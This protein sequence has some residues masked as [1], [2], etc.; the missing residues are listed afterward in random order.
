MQGSSRAASVR[1]ACRL[2]LQQRA[3]L[4]MRGSGRS[5]RAAA[6][7]AL[8]VLQAAGAS[9]ASRGWQVGL[10]VDGARWVLCGTAGCLGSQ[11]WSGSTRVMLARKPVHETCTCSACNVCDACEQ[12][13]CRLCC[14]RPTCITICL[15]Q[16]CAGWLNLS[17]SLLCCLFHMPGHAFAVM[18]SIVPVIECA[19]GD[20]ARFDDYN[21]C[22][23]FSNSCQHAVSL[24]MC[25]MLA[26]CK[27]QGGAWSWVLL[28]CWCYTTHGCQLTRPQLLPRVPCPFWSCRLK[29]LPLHHML[30]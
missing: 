1:A 28:T 17:C 3:W 12:F 16:Q 8:L 29:R 22:A 13:W 5:R 11:G 30:P 15:G 18:L 7:R 4:R 26:F 6:Q 2:L 25:M 19:V 20:L 23:A 24:Y 10:V 21:W 14:G 9:K 27:Q